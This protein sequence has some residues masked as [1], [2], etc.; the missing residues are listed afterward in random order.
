MDNPVNN[1]LSGFES[2]HR[3]Q[4]ELPRCV[5]HPP[6]VPVCHLQHRYSVQSPFVYALSI[7]AGGD[8]ECM[9]PSWRHW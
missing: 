6:A 5:K 7:D 4:S 8:E 3:A 1:A 2:Q 9:V